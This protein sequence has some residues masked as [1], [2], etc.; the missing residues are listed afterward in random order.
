M[1]EAPPEFVRVHDLVAAFSKRVAKDR[2]RARLEYKTRE[3]DSDE[4]DD[5]RLKDDEVIASFNLHKFMHKMTLRREAYEK[6]LEVAEKKLCDEMRRALAEMAPDANEPPVE[7]DYLGVKLSR[8]RGNEH[9]A[10]VLQVIEESEYPPVIS[11]R[12]IE[13]LLKAE[14]ENEHF[15]KVQ[16]DLKKE[17][18]DAENDF[19]GPEEYVD[20]TPPGFEDDPEAPVSVQESSGVLARKAPPRP[21]Y[22]RRKTVLDAIS[23]KS[24]RHPSA[25]GVPRRRRRC[26]RTRRRCRR[27][28]SPSRPCCRS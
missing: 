8:R 22:G 13:E 2:R 11:L 21:S 15:L 4:E 19:R 1:D 9:A 7:S 10:R 18:A 6:H 24:G 17:A 5:G 27:P 28:S 16:R 26:P 20:Y 3:P 23:S 12:Q 14:P 25:T